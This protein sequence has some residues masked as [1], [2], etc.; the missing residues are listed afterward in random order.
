MTDWQ[1]YREPLRATLTRTI[2]IAIVAGA[3]TSVAFGR[4]AR[5]PMMT[6][7]M[8]WPSF[9]GHWVELW[10]LNWLRPRLASARGVQIAARI[11][12]WFVGGIGLAFGMWLTAF[13]L[14]GLWRVPLAWWLAGFT[15]IGVELVAQLTLQ[16]RGRPSFY[17]GRG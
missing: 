9:G 12:V 2:G 15:F 16:M 14:T 7:L 8:L 13:A 4:P 17:N 3:V 5:W 6:V 1:P 11:A 10:F